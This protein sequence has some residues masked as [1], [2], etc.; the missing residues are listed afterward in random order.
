MITLFTLLTIVF[1][2]TIAIFTAA[3]YIVGGFIGLLLS[4]VGLFSTGGAT[5]VKYKEPKRRRGFTEE[6]IL[7]LGLYPDD[8]AYK[9]SI[10]SNILSK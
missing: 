9:M 6:E 4:S 10:I 1:H 3:A 7:A 5:T 8:E 2:A